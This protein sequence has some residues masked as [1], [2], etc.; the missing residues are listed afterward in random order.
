MALTDI[1]RIEL[2]ELESQESQV[3]SQNVDKSFWNRVA[4]GGQSAGQKIEERGSE[5]FGEA[6]QAFLE[7]EGALA[8]TFAG[9]NVGVMPFERFEA[10]I[11]NPVIALQNG[12]VNILKAFSKGVKGEQLG[13]FGDMYR[14][15]GIPEF[16]SAT[17]GLATGFIPI[18][19]V[20]G[21]GKNALLKATGL[22]KYADKSLK[23]AGKQLVKG[24]D[25]AVEFVGKNLDNIYAPVNK[26]AVDGLELLNAVDELPESVSKYIGKEVGKDF[27]I[28]G[29]FSNIE[30]VRKIK[31][32]VGE[33]RP[34]V[35]GKAERG[36]VETIEGK[37]I[38]K[39]YG[40]LKNLI[41]DS[42]E[43]QG[44]KKEGKLILEA[45]D[46]FS[47]MK[48]ASSFLKKA[49]VEGTLKLPTKAAKV[50][51]GIKSGADLSSRTAI[52]TILKGG[53]DAETAVIK[54]I[55]ALNK[56][57]RA[58]SISRVGGKILNY[59][60]L[61][62]VAGSIGARSASRTF[63]GDDFGSSGGGN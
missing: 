37:N 46:A 51:V 59:T 1:E 20:I 4:K 57:N 48:R 18:L 7:A 40:K 63:G 49:T 11:A 25:D 56:Y 36:A 28:V 55:S 13:E 19:K 50:A 29:D 3:N 60:I 10:A 22:S 12:D 15:A 41:Q 9:I 42:L 34:T 43:S 24:A 32:L 8:K 52:N 30:D 17:M 26:N 58:V 27:G 47:E 53:K 62:G 6:G 45:D 33:F 44:L 14:K 54:S 39:V 2:E 38:N 61:G 21:A 23:A 5:S 31:G 35:F 16:V